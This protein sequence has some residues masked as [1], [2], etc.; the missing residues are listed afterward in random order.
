M[1]EILPRFEFR[2][3]GQNFDRIHHRMSRLSMPV[4]EKLWERHSDETYIVASSIESLNVKIRSGKIDIK[5]RVQ[6]VDGLE[7][8]Y[9]RFL[10]AFP[11]SR[12]VLCEQVFGALQ[13]SLPDPSSA[14]CTEH[15]LLALVRAHPD[16]AAV[17]VR[18]QRFAYLVNES[19]CEYAVV[20]VNGAKVVTVATESADAGAVERAIIDV[21]MTALE[22]INY[23]DA[24]KR[25]IGMTPKRLAN[26]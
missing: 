26:E 4:P 12:E 19:I 20:L 11:L 14:V 6:S 8:W 15:H 21:G 13:V 1:S 25:V 17:R 24:I 10:D 23:P 16:L 9:P 3:V 22:N 7:Q 18:K 2:S 5:Q